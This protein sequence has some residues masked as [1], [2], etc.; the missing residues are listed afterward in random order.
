M[1]PEATARPV[2]TE[3]S[4]ARLVSQAWSSQE[5]QVGG[6][7]MVVEKLTFCPIFEIMSFLIIKSKASFLLALVCLQVRLVGGKI[8]R[9]AVTGGSGGSPRVARKQSTET[10]AVMASGAAVITVAAEE[11]PKLVRRRTWTKEELEMARVEGRRLEDQFEGA[12]K[13]TGEE[14]QAG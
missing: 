10:A 5:G 11:R 12:R 3:G 7:V 8:V 1:S 14:Y 4:Q 6:G 9:S 13:I 2:S